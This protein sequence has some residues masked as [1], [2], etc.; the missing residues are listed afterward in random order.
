MLLSFTILLLD[1]TI[2]SYWNILVKFDVRTCLMMTNRQV[3]IWEEECSI[4]NKGRLILHFHAIS[5]FI[6]GHTSTH[7][8]CC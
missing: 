4:I 6:D 3:G 8:N 1:G 7:D 5:M 2:A